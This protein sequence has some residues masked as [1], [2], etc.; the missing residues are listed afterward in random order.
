MGYVISSEMQMENLINLFV[1]RV[2]GGAF[3]WHSDST[4]NVGCTILVPLPLS[5]LLFIGCC[6]ATIEKS[7]KEWHVTY[8]S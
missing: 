5:S 2:G 4:N 6:Y 1:C 8:K 3:R 7:V